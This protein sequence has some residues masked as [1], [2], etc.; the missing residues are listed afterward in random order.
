MMI[1][2]DTC[3][4]WV[5]PLC[6]GLDEE[7]YWK[8]AEGRP[9]F[10]KY[11]CPDCSAEPSASGAVL[12]RQIERLVS[13]IQ[14]KRIQYSAE[15]LPR[16]GPERSSLTDPR[17]RSAL[18]RWIGER[19]AAGAAWAVATLHEAGNPFGRVPPGPRPPSSNSN[20]DYVV[21]GTP[22]DDCGECVYCRDKIKFGGPNVTKKPCLR[23]RVLK[24]SMGSSQTHSLALAAAE[25]DPQPG[26]LPA[27]G[28]QPQAVDE[29]AAGV[30]IKREAPGGLANGQAPGDDASGGTQANGV[31][32]PAEPKILSM[33]VNN[34]VRAEAWDGYD[35]Y[36]EYGDGEES[37]GAALVPPSALH[38]LCRVCPQQWRDAS[39][40][41]RGVR[42]S[43]R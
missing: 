40:E 26:S 3:L 28:S 7:T 11:E 17:R 16:L 34:G 5:H 23:R 8:Y 24:S 30:A 21:T 37:G 15:L 6:D 42:S 22:A 20:T 39:R 38:A 9:G 12:W 18:Q 19:A 35:S 1:Q 4:I 27:D 36:E 2:C 13:R 31:E 33:I 10:E 43:R 32:Q 29:E 14:H 41:R 25:A